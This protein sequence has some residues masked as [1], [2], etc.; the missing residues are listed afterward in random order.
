MAVELKLE[1]GILQAGAAEAHSAGPG[2]LYQ[3]PAGKLSVAAE[4]QWTDTGTGRD[5]DDKARRL[6]WFSSEAQL[7]KAHATSFSLT[8]Q[9]MRGSHTVLAVVRESVVQ[10]LFYKPGVSLFYCLWRC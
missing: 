4:F 7:I 1:V 8:P 2:S 3:L 10:F 6:K 9:R 5:E